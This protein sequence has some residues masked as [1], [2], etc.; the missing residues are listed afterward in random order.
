VP[1][2]IEDRYILDMTL[3]GADIN[4]EFVSFEEFSMHES[5]KQRYPTAE[6][7]FACGVDQIIAN[8]VV[9]ASPI[10]ITITDTQIDPPSPPQ[11]YEMRAFNF[12]FRPI[13]NFFKWYVS[14]QIDSK[15]LHTSVIKSYGK[16]TSSNAIAA[17]GIDG[18]LTPDC[19][20]TADVQVWLRPNERG[21]DF[22]YR[23]ARN[24]WAG[25]N[26]C[27]STA[28]TATKLLRHYNLP[29]RQAA[30]PV[31]TFLNRVE[32]NYKPSATEILFED[33]NYT[34][35]S[36][37]TNAY[38]GYGRTY[39]SYD[40]LKGFEFPNAN[41]A[42]MYTNAMN[43]ATAFQGSQ[44]SVTMA[45][46]SDNTHENYNLAQAQNLSIKAT[47]STRVDLTTRF[48]R[49]P[50]VLDYVKLMPYA[51]GL[52]EVTDGLITPWAGNYFISE[53]HTLVTPAA[54]GKKF[55]LL[56]EGL[57]I[58]KSLGLVGQE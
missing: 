56:R 10:V 51:M 43:M 33:A 49:H 29:Q 6:L 18:G 57:D 4:W 38:S 19:D 55:V 40:I 37:T 8:P 24:S 34:S 47:F 12:R 39:S 41:T 15:D 23:T 11:T 7:T 3:N 14:L 53:I 31:W 13:E 32:K 20:P 48:G 28:I 46:D 16:T 45:Y 1:R 22:I 21:S 9:D 58:N 27:F 5:V 54:I 36:G 2:I 44:R 50:Q 35:F 25:S 42:S 17:C 52:D 30:G 26:S